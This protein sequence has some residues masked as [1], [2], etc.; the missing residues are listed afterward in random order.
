MRAGSQTAAE[1]RTGIVL[2]R[3][4][5][6][7]SFAALTATAASVRAPAQQP[8]ESQSLLDLLPEAE[9]AAIRAGRPTEDCSAALQAAVDRGS[10]VHLP[11]GRYIVAKPIIFH[12][13]IVGRFAP[14][15][16]LIGE[17]S[18]YT[19]IE[20]RSSGRALF[21]FDG[22]ATEATGLRA[23]K[24]IR[25]EGFA[26]EGRRAAAT[27]AAIRLRGCYQVR[28]SDIHIID[29]RGS[30][31]VVPCLLGDLDGSNMITLDQV[32]IE[33]CAKWGLD[34]AG[35]PGRNEISF[36]SLRQVFLQ[37]CGTPA[38][39]LSPE[40]GG[41]RWKGQVLDLDQ[42]AFT[43]NRNVGL[44]IPGAAGL[45]LNAQL[46]SVAFE[47]NVGRHL[48]CTGISLFRGTNLQFYSDDEHQVA[49]ACEFAGATHTIRAVSIDGATIRATPRNAPYEAFRFVGP[50][51]EP[52]TCELRNIVWDNFGH[53]GQVRTV[54]EV[55]ALAAREV[56]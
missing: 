17:G 26:I 50:Q 31:I 25:L 42:C 49:V 54:G 20:D 9:R 7:T 22:G 40:S 51:L 29:R 32:R 56:G 14:G 21:D 23:I 10:T 41:M 48:F 37:N 15:V 43:E 18:G 1:D 3:R 28:L 39:S 55:P 12:P 45:G 47:N 34:A 4:N 36:V 2:S 53:P 16:S 19:I 33:N 35:A 13:R 27:T 52:R 30:G 6:L 8:A 44:F 5:T 38:D 11:A 46:S 24:G